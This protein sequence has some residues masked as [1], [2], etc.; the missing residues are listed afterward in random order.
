MH[1]NTDDFR[2]LTPRPRLY[3]VW[4]PLRDDGTLPLVSIW[5]DP[6]MAAFEPCAQ[7]VGITQTE[8]GKN[9]LEEGP[10]NDDKPGS[11]FGAPGLVQS[12][13]LSPVRE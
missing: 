1:M 4:T 10:S 6:E 11:R 2:D 3:R 5:I 8:N 7:E 9:N 12:H 13:L